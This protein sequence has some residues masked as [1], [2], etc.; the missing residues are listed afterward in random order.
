M[1]E[2]QAPKRN[3]PFLLIIATIL[4]LALVVFALQNAAPVEIRFFGADVTLPLAIIIFLT[5]SLGAI[6]GVLFSM[7]SI[8]KHRR[9]TKKLNKALKAMGAKVEEVKAKVPKAKESIPAKKPETK[10]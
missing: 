3:Y 5:F 7:P 10:A 1:T 6:I 9:N 4:A 8:L 2:V